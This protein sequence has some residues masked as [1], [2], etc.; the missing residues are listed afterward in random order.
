MNIKVGDMLERIGQL[1]YHRVCLIEA[2]KGQ[3]GVDV[4]VYHLSASNH[5]FHL[6]SCLHVYREEE[7]EE[8][9]M[10]VDTVHLST[11]EI[12]RELALGVDVIVYSHDLIKKEEL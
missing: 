5:M 12:V 11:E 10:I 3:N 4:T 7:I 1:Q 8:K 6:A 9:F 2:L